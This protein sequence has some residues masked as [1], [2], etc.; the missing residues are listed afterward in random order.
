MTALFF[1]LACTS[2]ADQA[3]EIAMTY[4]GAAFKPELSH[5]LVCL[6]LIHI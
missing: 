4:Q 5:P 1:F 6:S 3:V 2:P